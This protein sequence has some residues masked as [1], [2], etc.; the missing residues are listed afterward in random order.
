MF[1]NFDVSRYAYLNYSMAS[2][3]SQFA[4]IF[5]TQRSHGIV[6]VAEVALL[7]GA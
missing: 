3:Y 2:G 6:F 5:S 4:T 1:T 7:R